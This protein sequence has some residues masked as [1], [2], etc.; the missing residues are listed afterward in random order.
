MNVKKKMMVRITMSSYVK[1]MKT[2]GGRSQAIKIQKAM[3]M[4]RM[5][6][7]KNL[8]IHKKRLKMRKRRK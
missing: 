8:R 4:T 7:M 3:K 6:T 5:N 1:R 2:I